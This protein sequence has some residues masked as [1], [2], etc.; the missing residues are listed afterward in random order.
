[1]PAYLCVTCGVQFAPTPQPPVSCPI[2]QD[3]RQYVRRGG[4]SWTTSEELLAEGWRNE[5]AEVEPGLLTIN[6]RPAFGILIRV[7]GHFPGSSVLLWPS[8]AEGRGVLFSGDLP[9]VAA[10]PRWV[11]FLY[12]Y[13]NM[14]PLPAAEVRRIADRLAAYSFERIYGSW[15]E[16]VVPAEG[17]AVVARSAER[18]LRHLAD[19]AG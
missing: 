1:M 2:C 13:P 15:A 17:N 19:E 14:I 9:Q 8:G 3:E 7:G 16:K 11:S 12:S 18:Y 10:D 6:T 5:L 4:Q